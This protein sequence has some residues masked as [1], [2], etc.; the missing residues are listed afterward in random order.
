VR[1]N[2]RS[3]HTIREAQRGPLDSSLYPPPRGGVMERPVFVIPHPDFVIGGPSDRQ[4]A[5]CKVWR[6]NDVINTR[7]RS[8]A[9][10]SESLLERSWIKR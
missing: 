10:L 3:F 9:I 2:V 4:R 7:K 6:S 1:R 8:P 5:H